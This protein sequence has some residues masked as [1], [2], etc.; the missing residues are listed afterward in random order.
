MTGAQQMYNAT[1][2][3]RITGSTKYHQP[4]RECRRVTLIRAP[5]QPDSF[6]TVCCQMC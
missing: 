4:S 6:G 5:A 1:R 3:C 2:I